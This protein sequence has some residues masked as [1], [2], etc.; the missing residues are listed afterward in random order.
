MRGTDVVR[1]LSLQFPFELTLGGQASVGDEDSKSSSPRL[2]KVA[3]KCPKYAFKEK[4]G[5]KRHVFDLHLLI[6]CIYT[7]AF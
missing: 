5:G 7:M 1:L 2:L 6:E 3:T 4:I